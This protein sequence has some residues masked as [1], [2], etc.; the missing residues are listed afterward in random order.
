MSNRKAR[1]PLEL[2]TT[3]H[4]NALLR[5][6]QVQ[7]LVPLP[8]ATIYKAMADG[9]FPK[10]VRISHRTVAWRASDILALM[11][12]YETD[13]D[14]NPNTAKALAGSAAKRLL[15]VV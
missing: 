2:P 6:E 8:K 4:P 3:L 1:K 14:I 15:G 5:I 9:E 11:A 7:A 13:T 10:P 12:G